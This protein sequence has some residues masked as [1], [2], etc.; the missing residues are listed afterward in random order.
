[1]QLFL[2]R[3]DFFE[4]CEHPS[5]GIGR[6]TAMRASRLDR[7][8]CGTALCGNLLLYVSNGNARTHPV[9]KPGLIFKKLNDVHFRRF[10]ERGRRGGHPPRRW[11]SVYGPPLQGI[12][13]SLPSTTVLREVRGSQDRQSLSGSAYFVCPRDCNDTLPSCSCTDTQGQTRRGLQI[14]SSF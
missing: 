9:W 12:A 2:R 11:K 6:D 13:A 4:S 7:C 10:R 8:V 3:I 14:T 5:R 1:M